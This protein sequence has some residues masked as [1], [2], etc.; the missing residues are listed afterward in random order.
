MRG[1]IE[2]LPIVHRPDTGIHANMHDEKK[3]QE[4]A[5]EAHY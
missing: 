1:D 3:D 4:Y 5:G 2:H